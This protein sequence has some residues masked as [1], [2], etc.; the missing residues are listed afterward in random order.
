MTHN[1]L[2]GDID[3]LQF[4]RSRTLETPWL[5]IRAIVELHKPGINEAEY[6]CKEC[7]EEYPCCTIEAIEKELK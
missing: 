3:S 7:F 5:T 6:L 4:R 1:E 2:L